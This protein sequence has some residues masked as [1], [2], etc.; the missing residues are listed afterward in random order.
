MSTEEYTRWSPVGDV[1]TDLVCEALHDDHEGIRV[2]LRTGATPGRMLRIAFEAVVCYRN[3]NESY[4]LRT[5]AQHA[6]EDMGGLFRVNES[7][8]VSWVRAES[9]GVLEGKQLSHYAILTG[10]DCIEFI[11]EFPPEVGWVTA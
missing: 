9:G 8:W 11:S 5:W 10:E 4:R 7:D 1:P 3:I 6:G 2:L